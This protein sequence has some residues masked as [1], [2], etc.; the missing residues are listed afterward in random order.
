MDAERMK[1]RLSWTLW[2]HSS[3]TY[4]ELK[5]QSLQVR[6]INSTIMTTA[7][8]GVKKEREQRKKFEIAGYDLDAR[9]AT[10]NYTCMVDMEL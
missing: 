6:N 10:R 8:I 4:K 7:L 5:K 3:G 9:Y 1:W 2:L